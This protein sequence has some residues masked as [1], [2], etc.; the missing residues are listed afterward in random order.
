VSNMR[1]FWATIIGDLNFDCQKGVVRD[2]RRALASIF[3]TDGWCSPHFSR[4]TVKFG[5][6]GLGTRID[7]QYNDKQVG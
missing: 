2:L 5:A 6:E 1:P 3:D 4:K 7:C